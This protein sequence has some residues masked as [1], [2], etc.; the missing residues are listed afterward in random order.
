MNKC[1]FQT[2]K[3]EDYVTSKKNLTSVNRSNC[4]YLT[5]H[6]LR[7]V[8]MEINKGGDRDMKKN[9]QTSQKILGGIH[10]Q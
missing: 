7:K 9:P 4:N 5:L 6:N 10:S 1:A 2:M 8:F 3:V